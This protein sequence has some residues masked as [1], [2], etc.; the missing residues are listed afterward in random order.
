[1]FHSICCRCAVFGFILKSNT[2]HSDK[3]WHT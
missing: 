3:T 2:C 1:M